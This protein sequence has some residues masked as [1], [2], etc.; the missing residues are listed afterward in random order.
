MHEINIL[1]FW[2][3]FYSK[4]NLHVEIKATYGCAIVLLAA[5]LI[6]PPAMLSFPVLK[7]FCKY[8]PAGIDDSKV[9]A[10]LTPR[11][12]SLISRQAQS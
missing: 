7:S 9:T 1:L 2:F 4:E 3:F 10:L 12:A 6:Q 11:A 8:F 5:Q